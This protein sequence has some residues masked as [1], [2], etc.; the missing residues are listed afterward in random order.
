MNLT[1]LILNTTSVSIPTQWQMTKAKRAYK[2]IHNKCE[3]CG[4]TKNLEVHHIVPVHIDHTLACD[5]ENFIT[6]CDTRNFGCHYKWGHFHN[7]RSNWNPYI[8]EFA[9]WVNKFNL[10]IDS[11]SNQI[12]LNLDGHSF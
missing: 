1:R 11:N 12:Y 7:F 9:E 2:K 10:D 3:L 6:L 4:Y 8:V 5:P